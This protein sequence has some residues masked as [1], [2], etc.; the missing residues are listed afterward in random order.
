MKRALLSLALLSFFL[1]SSPTFANVIERTSDS[2]I[3]VA[4]DL[5][6]TIRQKNASDCGPAA[7]F[8]AFTLGTALQQRKIQ[9]LEGESPDEK[10][11]SFVAQLASKPSEDDEMS[12]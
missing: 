10:Y 1:P 12:A 11:A 5:E 9:E 2:M 6:K 7:L 8:N 4:V 3:G